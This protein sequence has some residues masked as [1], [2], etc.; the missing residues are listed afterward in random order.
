MDLD[1]LLDDLSKI[2]RENQF[3]LKKD[4]EIKN[5]QNEWD[6]DKN[7]T[8]RANSPKTRN[9]FEKRDTLVVDFIDEWEN[10]TL[11]TNVKV[12]DLK[13]NKPHL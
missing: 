9:D 11:D 8:P 10:L 5:V 4:L 1:E 12:D 2:S 3:Q 7:A 13:K 6:L